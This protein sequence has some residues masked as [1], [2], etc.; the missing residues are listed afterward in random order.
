MPLRQEEEG[1][2]YQA[3]RCGLIRD[4]RAPRRRPRFIW[5]PARPG[6][7]WPRCPP[8]PALMAGAQFSHRHAR[9]G[10]Q[11]ATSAPRRPRAPLHVHL[12][13]C[14]PRPPLRRSL[15]RALLVGPRWL[16]RRL[17]QAHF[18]ARLATYE[19][20]SPPRRWKRNPAPRRLAFLASSF[21]ASP[22]PS[23]SKL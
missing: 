9:Q 21:E 20:R 3:P 23:Q 2:H 12:A 5:P 19:P 1:A 10:A 18:G 8:R 22:S 17:W 6:T 11:G 15:P 13:T 16:L 14:G 7:S 4:F